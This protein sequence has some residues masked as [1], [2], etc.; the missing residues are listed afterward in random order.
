MSSL[1]F[2]PEKKMIWQKYLQDSSTELERLPRSIGFNIS[3]NDD[4]FQ[5]PLDLSD[6]AVKDH[7]YLKIWR[8]NYDLPYKLRRPQKVLIVAG[9]TGNDAAAA[10]RYNV[11]EIDVVEIDGTIIELGKMY[12][13]EKPYSDPR[14]RLYATDA[15]SFFHSTDQVYDMIIFSYL[16][17]HRLFLKYPAYGWILFSILSKVSWKRNNYFGQTVCYMFTAQQVKVGWEIGSSRCFLLS[18]VGHLSF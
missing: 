15:R 9:G 5:M 8:D 3:I 1:L 18:L 4:Y 13:P 10:I 16:D 17:S 2:E 12:H 6:Q 14:V 7:A 11:P